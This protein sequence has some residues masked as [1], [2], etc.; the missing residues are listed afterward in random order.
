MGA[1]AVAFILIS[2]YIYVSRSTFQIHVT[3]R[4]DGHRYYFRCGAYGILFCTIG[5]MI[6]LVLDGFDLPSFLLNYIFGTSLEELL[7]VTRYTKTFQEYLSFKLMLGS[8]FAVLLAPIGAKLENAIR[9]EE[10]MRKYIHQEKSPALE[11]FLFEC[12]EK[13]QTVLITLKSRKVYVGIVNDIPIESGEVEHFTLL[14]ILSG[15]REKDKL[16]VIF[17]TN[18]YQHYQHHLDDNGEPINGSGACLDDFVEMIPVSEIAHIGSFDIDTYKQF[19]KPVGHI[20]WME[21]QSYSINNENIV[22][23][24]ED[25]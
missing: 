24:Q 19:I 20:P 11:K 8:G 7:G 9:D 3:R 17:T 21:P 22:Y 13:L 16:T 25:R 6:T 12:G 23:P 18:Y 10:K 1:F 4:E 5:C 14:P 15:Y 2:G